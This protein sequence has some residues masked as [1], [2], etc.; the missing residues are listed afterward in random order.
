MNHLR[1]QLVESIR[2]DPT[3]DPRVRAEMA[4]NE[5]IVAMD[6]LPVHKNFLAEE[7][8]PLKQAA[9]RFLNFLRRLEEQH[10]PQDR[11]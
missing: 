5:A 8:V 9:I 11:I 2:R 4:A 6:L 10:T 3:M 7:I 1:Q